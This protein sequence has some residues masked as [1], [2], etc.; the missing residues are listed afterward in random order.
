VHLGLRTNEQ[1][2]LDYGE[3]LHVIVYIDR[4]P[5]QRSLL[6]GSFPSDKDVAIHFLDSFT[7]LTCLSLRQ[8]W[9]NGH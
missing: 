5:P 3:S 7:R 8:M 4:E 2:D 6:G 1:S 9:F